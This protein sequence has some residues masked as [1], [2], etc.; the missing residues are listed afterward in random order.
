MQIIKRINN[1][2]AYIR[3]STKE[4]NKDRQQEA[5]KEYAATSS[6]K[7]KAIFEDRS[8]GKDFDRSQYIAL[9]E[10]VKPGDTIIIKELDTP[11][12]STGD[13]RL[14]YTINNML[15]NFLYYIADKERDK[16]Q[17]RV[18]EGLKNAKDKGVKLGRPAP[19][20]YLLWTYYKVYHKTHQIS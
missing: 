4:Q 1:I 15:I 3:V 5:L 17:C 18:I 8:R 16:I 2:Y 7:Y 6:I 10:I 19:I 13:N 20:N 11:L 9:K 12:V 14:D